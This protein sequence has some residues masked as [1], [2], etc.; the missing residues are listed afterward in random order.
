MKV[1]VDQ[2]ITSTGLVTSRP[3]AARMSLRFS[4]KLAV[5][6]VP[7]QTQFSRM[8]SLAR[9]FREVLGDAAQRR[10]RRGVGD[11]TW[12]L[13][14]DRVCGQVTMRARSAA[15]SI[16]NAA[17]IERMPDMVPKANAASHSASDISSK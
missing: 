7:G 2:V 16:D 11:D 12:V 10:L 13:T 9:L 15:R 14:P 5:T 17:R 3:S 8:P 1:V 6:M 4:V